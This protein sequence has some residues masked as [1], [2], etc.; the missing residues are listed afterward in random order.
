VH[1]TIAIPI[2]GNETVAVDRAAVGAAKR[3]RTRRARTIVALG[4]AVAV[5]TV[6]ITNGPLAKVSVPDVGGRDEVAAKQLL[7]ARGFEVD[8]SEITSATVSQG[9]VISQSPEPP[10]SIR[11]GGL[12]SLV[13]SAGPALVSLDDVVGLRFAAAERQLTDVGFEVLRVDV[14]DPTVPRLHVVSQDPRQGIVEEGGTVTLTVSKGPE[15][16]PVPN[17][18]GDPEEAAARDLTD[19][20]FVPKIVR[21]IDPEV[22][23]GLVIAVRPKPGVDVAKGDEVTLVVSLGPPLVKVPN[24]GCMTRKQ[25]EDRLAASD[26]KIEFS[27]HGQRVVD[28]DPTPSSE[29]PEGSVVTAFMGFGS[30]C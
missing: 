19:A 30:Y 6:M 26:L 28:Q 15:M 10:A 8:T 14:F 22:R 12:V 27:G 4:V 7:R 23:K 13:I 17:V 21:K 25:A 5:V 18:I 1:Q 11:K 24:I 20:G 9:I 29:A 3:R 2:L 16:I